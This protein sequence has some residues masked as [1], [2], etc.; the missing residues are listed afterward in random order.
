MIEV[1]NLIF[2]YPNCLALNDVSLTI[3]EGTITALVGPN[4]AGKTTLMKCLAALEKPL[5][6]SITIDGIDII[7]NPRDCHRLLGFLPDFFGLYD[8][9]R[10]W[11]C[12]EYFARIHEVPEHEIAQ[13]VDETAARMDLT[14]KLYEPVTGLSRGMRQRLAIGQT[15]IQK[16]KYLVLD[17]PAS[18]LDPEARFALGEEFLR[19]KDE[20]ITLI[21]SS[22]ILAELDQYA[23]ELLIIRNGKVVEHTSAAKLEK[24]RNLLEVVLSEFA[25]P[26]RASIESVAAGFELTITDDRIAIRYD[27]DDHAQQALLRGLIAAGVPVKEFFVKRET[28]QDQYLDTVR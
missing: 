12:L 9:L 28:L 23:T 4:G 7:E 20:G 10:V 15:I 17:E 27:G 8:E 13:R 16:P 19:L 11:Q 24:N 2:E 18:G 1:K 3:E 22:H 21:V 6:G 14:D 26:Y 5:A 25:E